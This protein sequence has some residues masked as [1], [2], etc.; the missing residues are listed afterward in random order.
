MSVYGFIGC[1]NMGSAL[2]KSVAKKIGG[3]NILL[4]DT[5]QKKISNLSSLGYGKESTNDEIAKFADYI[6]IGVKPQMCEELLREI[7][8]KV[9]EREKPVFISMAAGV[10]INDLSNMLFPS[11]KIIRIMPNTPA[12][13]GEGM[14]LYS[15][16]KNTS[17]E[18]I[19][20]FLLSFSLCGM[21]DPID[22]KIIDAASA[23]SGCG[24]AFVFMFIQSL[25][26]AGVKC[27][28]PR[29][30][31]LLYAEQTVLGAAKLALESDEHPEKLKDA[32]CSPAGSTIEGVKA[33]EE[34][35]F[36]ASAMNAVK[37]AYK[38]TLELGK[39]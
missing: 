14:I 15:T 11:A 25:A 18:E 26:D 27:G 21:I 32:V 30:K 6:V 9:Q 22:E 29:D 1:G 20:D 2:I 12:S 31:A 8:L 24:P 36:R 23:V 7:S 19:N 16:S 28:L 5:N 4:S 10:S 34:G 13:V 37:K 35:A 38:R 17:Q 39:K 33:L 3:N